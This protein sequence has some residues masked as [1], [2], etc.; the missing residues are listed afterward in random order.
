MNFL[1]AGHVLLSTPTTGP[2]LS[3]HKASAKTTQTNIPRPGFDLSSFSKFLKSAPTMAPNRD[4]PRPST[5]SLSCQPSQ[6]P[7]QLIQ[8]HLFDFQA[9]TRN[10]LNC[11]G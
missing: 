5:S 9:E 7:F 2:M 8:K 6:S 11:N 1:H 3:T 10:K 4:R